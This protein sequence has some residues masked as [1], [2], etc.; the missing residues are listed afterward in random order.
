MIASG[1]VRYHDDLADHLVAIDAVVPHEDNPNNGDL[2]AV[3]ASVLAHGMYRPLYAQKSTKR[4]LAG[5]TTWMACADLGATQV[6]VI[7][8]DVDDTTALKILLADN[9]TALLAKL[10]P[11]LEANALLALDGD[12]EGTG[13]TP[14]DIEA[15]TRLNN[16]PLDP[17]FNDPWP[18]ICVQVPH[19]VRT[20]YLR[21]TDAAGGDRERFETIL[22]LAGWDG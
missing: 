19:H 3:T 18:T 15:L 2:D 8:L 11:A 5:H 14:K 16:T 17:G 7:W 21:M 20:A 10:D 4:I 13:Y 22:R 6:P 12:I 9:K 1:L